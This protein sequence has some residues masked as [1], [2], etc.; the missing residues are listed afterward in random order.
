MMKFMKPRPNVQSSTAGYG[1]S[2]NMT[3]LMKP[4]PKVQSGTTGYGQ[5]WNMKKRMKSRPMQL[6]LPVFLL[7]LTCFNATM[8]SNK[9]KAEDFVFHKSRN[10]VYVITVSYGSMNETYECQPFEGSC[11]YTF[12]GNDVCEIPKD[13][14][15]CGIDFEDYD[16]ETTKNHFSGFNELHKSHEKGSSSKLF[17]LIKRHHKRRLDAILKQK[18][19]R[20]SENTPFDICHNIMR[21]EC[22]G[23]DIDAQLLLKHLADVAAILKKDLMEYVEEFRTKFRSANNINISYAFRK[24]KKDWVDQKINNMEGYITKNRKASS[25]GSK[26]TKSS[27]EICRDILKEA[28]LAM[29]PC[30]TLQSALRTNHQVRKDAGK[31]SHN[32]L[33]HCKNTKETFEMCKRYRAF[34]QLRITQFINDWTFVYPGQIKICTAIVKK[35]WAFENDDIKVATSAKF[36]LA[37]IKSKR[38][39]DWLENMKNKVTPVHRESLEKFIKK[40]A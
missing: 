11:S 2:W 28:G 6:A 22:G 27:R 25:G 20:K 29:V 13:R 7:L 21:V 24:T 40:F 23:D 15:F 4:R 31:I 10:K 3:K 14:C 17:A 38:T 33:D 34:I 37:F 39:K 1:Q 9:W 26:K 12:S 30:R 32:L 19:Q 8:A 36:L 35:L 18:P 16:Y 5:S